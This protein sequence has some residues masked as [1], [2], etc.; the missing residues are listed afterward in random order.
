MFGKILVPVDGSDAAF[1]AASY[2]KGI[3][4]KFESAV[5]LLHVIEHPGYLSGTNSFPASVLQ[6][7]DKNGEQVLARALELFADFD[8]RVSTKLEYGHAGIKITELSKENSYSLIIMG[9]RGLSGVKQLLMGSV[10]NYVLHYAQC[11]TL[12][13]KG[14][15]MSKK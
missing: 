7:M 1:K 8:G 11:P 6:D 14:E 4:E 15:C 12:I 10:S 9:R 3:A 13:I 5:T 2:A